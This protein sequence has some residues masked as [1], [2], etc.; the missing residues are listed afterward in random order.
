MRTD[1]TLN[2]IRYRLGVTDPV[3]K[4]TYDQGEYGIQPISRR[5]VYLC[6]SLGEPYRGFAYKL[7]AAIINLPQQQG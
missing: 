1:F 6:I 4:S 3:V 7:V 5:N 2:T